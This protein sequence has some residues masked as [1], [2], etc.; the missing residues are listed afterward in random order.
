[1]HREA[2]GST[3]RRETSTLLSA[4]LLISL[5]HGVPHRFNALPRKPPR[6]GALRSVVS[7]QMNRLK[8]RFREAHRATR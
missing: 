3:G 6:T 7:Q 2:I 8:R 4:V 1:M 5:A